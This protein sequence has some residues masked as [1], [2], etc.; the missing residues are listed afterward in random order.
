LNEA[1]GF[2]PFGFTPAGY[3]DVGATF[4]KRDRGSATNACGS[5]GD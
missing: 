5:A 2:S 4:S 1:N 3:H